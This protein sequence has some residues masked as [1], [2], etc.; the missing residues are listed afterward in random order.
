LA[1]PTPTFKPTAP[2]SYPEPDAAPV[3]RLDDDIQF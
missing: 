2:E 1:A 3:G